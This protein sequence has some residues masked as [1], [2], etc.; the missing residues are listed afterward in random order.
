MKK[1]IGLMLFFLFFSSSL[2]A[3]EITMYC[4]AGKAADNIELKYTSSFIFGKS[5]KRR[6]NN[7]WV[8]FCTYLGQTLNIGDKKAICSFQKGFGTFGHFIFTEEFPR[9]I[10]YKYIGYWVMDFSKGEFDVNNSTHY[11]TN[12]NDQLGQMDIDFK[13]DLLAK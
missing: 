1:Q 11:C 9:G 13:C 7:K 10:N 4:K 6:S 8:D 5:L 3:E 12:C 2:L